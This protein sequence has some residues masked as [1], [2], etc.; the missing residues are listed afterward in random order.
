[1]AQYV[2]GPAPLRAALKRGVFHP[3]RCELE[4]TEE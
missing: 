4:F 1:M 2:S 3:L